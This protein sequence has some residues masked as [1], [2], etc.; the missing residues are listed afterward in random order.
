M[1]KGRISNL[2]TQKRHHLNEIVPHRHPLRRTLHL[3]NAR[4]VAVQLDFSGKVKTEQEA[5]HRL[6]LTPTESR[7]QLMCLLA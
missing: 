7:K 6:R 4:E 3:A 1:N 2:N 5:K